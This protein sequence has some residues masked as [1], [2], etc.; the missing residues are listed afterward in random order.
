MANF[1]GLDLVNYLDLPDGIWQPERLSD[2]HNALGL[3]PKRIMYLW[4]F[5]RHDSLCGQLVSHGWTFIGPIHLLVS[6]GARVESPL[7][8]ST[9]AIDQAIGKFESA[10]GKYRCPKLLDYE[11]RPTYQGYPINCLWCS[12]NTWVH[13]FEV[14][15]KNSDYFVADLSADE[16][17]DG[18]ITEIGYLF[19]RVPLKK[20][21]F[22]LDTRTA[23]TSLVNDFLQQAW[24]AM[25]SDAVN[26]G[27]T[28]EISVIIYDTLNL[29]YMVQATQSLWL[30]K[31]KVPLARRAAQYMGW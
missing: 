15:A 18:L 14:T 3:P 2:A 22:L 1:P 6:P 23:D 29:R 25:S 21:I 20:V 7:L 5:D 17:P 24:N 10:P 26:A 31:S 27:W 28:K 12:N 16:Q 11:H 13:G 8:R 4:L 19:H 9:Q 30:G